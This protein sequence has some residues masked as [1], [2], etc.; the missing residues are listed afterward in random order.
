VRY[1]TILFALLPVPLL[2]QVYPQAGV[3]DP[4][5]QTVQYDPAQ[6]IRLSLAPGF[7]TIIELA[8]GDDIQTIGVGD[9]AAWQVSAGKRGNFFFVK[10]VNAIALTNLSVITSSRIYNFELVPSSG[11]GEVSPY[12]V[13]IVYPARAND[14]STIIANPA[15]EYRLSGSKNIR[16]SKVYQEGSQTILEWLKDAPLPGIFSLEN[17][18]EALVNGAMQDGRFVIAGTPEKLVFRLDRKIA[19]ATRQP[20]RIAGDE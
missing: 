7:Q 5:I 8:P 15:F 6:V 16:P 11:Y 9:S 1:L 18:S 17:G 2:A 19:Y 3:G 10:N 20:V 13:R 12:H 4:R 14:A